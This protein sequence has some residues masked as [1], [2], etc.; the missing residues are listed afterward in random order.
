VFEGMEV[1]DLIE[2]GDAIVTVSVQ[3]EEA[4]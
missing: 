1:V 4:E 3:L 2:E